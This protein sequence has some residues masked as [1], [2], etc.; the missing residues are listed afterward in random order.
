MKNYWVLFVFGFLLVFFGIVRFNNITPMFIL[1][2]VA[3]FV[4]GIYEWYKVQL[5]KEE[6]ERRKRKKKVE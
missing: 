6:A 4:I 1:F 2:G 3:V 5:E